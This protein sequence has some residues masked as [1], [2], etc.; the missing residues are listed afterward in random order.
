[1]LVHNLV[2]AGVVGVNE[3]GKMAMSEKHGK[4]VQCFNYDGGY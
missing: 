4:F 1:M 2:V 3:T